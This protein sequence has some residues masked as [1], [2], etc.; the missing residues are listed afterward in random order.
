MPI[1]DDDFEFRDDCDL[2]DD[3]LDDFL[4]DD[5]IDYDECADWGG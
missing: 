2:S 1:D 3:E 4:S 5:L